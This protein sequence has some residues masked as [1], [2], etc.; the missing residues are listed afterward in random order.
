MAQMMG[1]ENHSQRA[2][3]NN[4]IMENKNDHISQFEFVLCVYLGGEGVCRM[5]SKLLRRSPNFLRHCASLLN[6]RNLL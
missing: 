2:K 6:V 3:S 5:I 1:V 4:N